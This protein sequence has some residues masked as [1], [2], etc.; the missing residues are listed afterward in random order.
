MIAS[1]NNGI[2]HLHSTRTVG[3]ALEQL[4]AVLRTKRVTVFAIV[5]HSGE[6]AKVG[7]EM[8]ETKL[9]V[10]G[11]P[12]AGTPLML[13]VPE[14]ALDLPLKILIAAN[15]K[16]GIRVSYNSVAYL[17]ARFGLTPEIA[18][19]VA[20]IEQIAIATAG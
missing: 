11:S 4:L 1:S 12:S 20:A 2:I 9:V 17:Q 8:P 18:A 7:F 15:P 16:Q 19:H 3:Q 10:F 6:A 5:D 13:S 14:S